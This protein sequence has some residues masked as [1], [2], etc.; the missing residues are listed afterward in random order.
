MV[1][2]CVILNRLIFLDKETL[3]S[4][5]GRT[6]C[7]RELTTS[8]RSL[9]YLGGSTFREVFSYIELNLIFCNRYSFIDSRSAEQCHTEAAQQWGEGHSS[10]TVTGFEPLALGARKFLV[11]LKKEFK[12]KHGGDLN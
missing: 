7:V 3:D 11:L 4:I 9:F 2:R 5:C 12:D 10:E 8:L 6:F 1:G